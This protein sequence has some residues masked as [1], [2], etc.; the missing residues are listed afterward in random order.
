MIKFNYTF[1]SEGTLT[2]KVASPD[3]P[4]LCMTAYSDPDTILYLD[5]INRAITINERLINTVIDNGG[6]YYSKS[7][8]YKNTIRLGI[9]TI[10][11]K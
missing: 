7:E 1:D 2:S 11:G 3:A 8:K 9:Y 4:T 10:P 6:V 5:D